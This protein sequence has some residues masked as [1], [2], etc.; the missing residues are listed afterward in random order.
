M[1]IVPRLVMVRR[2]VAACFYTDELSEQENLR[3]HEYPYA[4]LAL[5]AA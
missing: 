3:L 5:P 2:A 1:A 4:T